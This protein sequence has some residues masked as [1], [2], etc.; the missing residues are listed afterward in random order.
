M[1]TFSVDKS[2]AVLINKKIKLV[3]L[4]IPSLL[5]NLFYI[6]FAKSKKHKIENSR[7]AKV[8]TRFTVG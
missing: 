1:M 7:K 3:R 5:Y 8:Y 4:H 2:Q 6:L